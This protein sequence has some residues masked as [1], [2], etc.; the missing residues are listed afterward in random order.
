MN[1]ELSKTLMKILNESF[2]SAFFNTNHSKMQKGRLSLEQA[3]SVILSPPYAI[4]FQ[5]KG[6]RILK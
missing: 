6:N 1:S 4:L 5:Q 3:N 2:F